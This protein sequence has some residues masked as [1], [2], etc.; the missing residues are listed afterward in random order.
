M[1]NLAAAPS[2]ERN[3]ACGSALADALITQPTRIPAATRHKLNL[4]VGKYLK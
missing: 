2:A 1:R 3:C 4:L